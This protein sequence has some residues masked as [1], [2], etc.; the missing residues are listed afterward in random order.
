MTRRRIAWALLLLGLAVGLTFVYVRFVW[1]AAPFEWQTS[2][3]HSYALVLEDGASGLPAATVQVRPQQTKGRF[4][5]VA[6][7]VD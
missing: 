5:F 7:R 3:G 2:E 4:L 6:Y 1:R